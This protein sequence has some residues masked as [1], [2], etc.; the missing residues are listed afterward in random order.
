[1][2]RPARPEYR[3]SSPVLTTG[4]GLSGKQIEGT[5]ETLAHAGDRYP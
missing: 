2:V 1:L 3:I 5:P 4:T